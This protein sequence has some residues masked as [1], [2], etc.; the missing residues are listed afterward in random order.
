L[1]TTGWSVLIPP[2][3]K[4][5]VAEASGIGIEVQVLGVET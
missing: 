3:Q 4:P 5:H 2:S 1:V